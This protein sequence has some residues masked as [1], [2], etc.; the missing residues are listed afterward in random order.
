MFYINEGELYTNEEELDIKVISEYIE[1][2]QAKYQPKLKMLEE[3]YNRELSEEVV[4]NLQ[5]YIVDTVT[6]YTFG[7]PIQ[8]SNVS[9]DYLNNMTEIDEDSHNILLAKD[10]AIFGRAYEFIFVDEDT[11]NVQLINLS[12]IFATSFATSAALPFSVLI[13]IL[14][15]TAG[16]I[17]QSTFAARTFAIKSL[18]ASKRS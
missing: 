11:D 8:Y 7:E 13:A 16:S 4:V 2:F 15:F 10:M 17:P 5:K 14:I 18:R 12:P 9:E 6:S 3:K 1:L